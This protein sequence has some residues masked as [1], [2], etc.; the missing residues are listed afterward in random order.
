MM[1]LNRVT[2]K[3]VFVILVCFVQRLLQSDDAVRFREFLDGKRG[4]LT[5][6]DVAAFLTAR[7]AEGSGGSEPG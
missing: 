2:V 1:K 3:V 7:L 4:K 6:D 5:R